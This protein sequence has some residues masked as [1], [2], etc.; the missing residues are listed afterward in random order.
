MTARDKALGRAVDMVLAG[1]SDVTGFCDRLEAAGGNA[2]LIA[3]IRR[4]LTA[5]EPRV[6]GV[7]LRSVWA[8]AAGD[9]IGEVK[10]CA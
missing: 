3:A 1:I 8:A 7:P 9:V 2:R 10:E 5:R 4:R 6:V